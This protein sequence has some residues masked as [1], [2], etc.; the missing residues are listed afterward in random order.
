MKIPINPDMFTTYH[1][2]IHDH[3]QRPARYVRI[4]GILEHLKNNAQKRREAPKPLGPYLSISWTW[5][6]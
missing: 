2:L 6:P 4:M 3:V 5:V 1:V